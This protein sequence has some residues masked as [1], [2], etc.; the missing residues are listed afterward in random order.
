[1]KVAT[2]YVARSKVQKMLQEELQNLG[3]PPDPGV[4]WIEKRWINQLFKL[5][6]AG[7]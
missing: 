4:E 2:A 3:S 1:M 6:E 5:I 7:A